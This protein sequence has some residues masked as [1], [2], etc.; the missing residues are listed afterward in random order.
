MTVNWGAAPDGTVAVTV[1]HGSAAPVS[2][3]FLKDTVPPLGTVVV[4]GGVT[5]TGRSQVPLRLDA[6]DLSGVARVAIRGSADCQGDGAWQP[7][8]RGAWWTLPHPG[9]DNPVGVLFE[10]GAGNPSPCWSTVITHDRFLLA[11]EPAWGGGQ[12]WND[13][14]DA[15]APATRC[16]VS[17][18]ATV[19]SCLHA[20]EARVVSVTTSET[21]A[22]ATGATD[23]LGAFT[24][25]GCVQASGRIMFRTLGLQPGK[26]LADLVTADG[27]RPI[28]VTVTGLGDKSSAEEP[29]WSNPVEPLPD[30]PGGGVTRLTEPGV[31][32]TVSA[33]RHLHGVGMEAEGVSLVTL[34]AAALRY[35]GSV[36]TNA[37]CPTSPCL[38]GVGAPFTW[39][40]GRLDGLGATSRA[41]VCVYVGVGAAHGRVGPLRAAHCDYGLWL[42]GDANTVVD[43]V[44]TSHGQA[45]HIS[46]GQDNVLSGLVLAGNQ[47]GGRIY[48]TGATG[49]VLTMLTVTDNTEDGLRAL[50]V[51]GGTVVHNAVLANN[52]G[53]GLELSASHDVTVGQCAAAHN[54]SHGLLLAG[55]NGGV[56]TGNLLVGGNAGSACRVQSGTSPGLEDGTCAPT[57][58]SDAH[59][60][61]GL[62]LADAFS[63]AVTEDDVANPSD[64]R[65]SATLGLAVDL[66]TFDNPTRAWGKEGDAFPSPTTR[67]A[68]V[69]G[70]GRIRDWSLLAAGQN[71]L[72]NRAGDGETA[73]GNVWAPGPCPDLVGGEGAVSHPAGGGPAFLTTAVEVVTDLLGDNDGLCESDE[74]CLYAPNLGAYQGHGD[75]GLVPCTLPGGEVSGVTLY[76]RVSNGR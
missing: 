22:D 23:S 54:G 14:V 68:W 57:G 35:G 15:L 64:D 18:H 47:L 28:K 11:A 48:G 12:D 53:V 40:E 21:C 70:A 56:F 39:V 72:R 24:W 29:W 62:G 32:H 6:T 65:G 19:G 76:A 16:D 63:G 1:E 34:G 25:S 30:P 51:P 37:V 13:Y 10:D 8:Q 49:N 27:W 74:T 60:V 73:L 17:T 2:R 67:G 45:L 66:T 75:L 33:S 36:F 42:Q 52:G 38:V 43:A 50:G 55:S 9:A 58:S 26:G 46:S 41:V 69:S 20:G 3:T 7:Y 4:N 61:A 31:V 44:L 71:P 59:V 5:R